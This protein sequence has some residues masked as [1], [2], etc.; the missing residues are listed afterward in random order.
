MIGLCQV[1]CTSL[2]EL[3]ACF[4]HFLHW[5]ICISFN[6]V[7]HNLAT[8][9]FLLKG[10]CFWSWLAISGVHLYCFSCEGWWFAIWR[11]INSYKIWTATMQCLHVVKFHAVPG[12]VPRPSPKAHVRGGSRNE[13]ACS[14]L[15]LGSERASVIMCMHDDDAIHHGH[16]GGICSLIIRKLYG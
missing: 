7:L 10:S 1:S 11:S 16:N 12:L 13:T 8:F 6:G 3:V 4:M 9:C 2:Y 15:G 5:L 14:S